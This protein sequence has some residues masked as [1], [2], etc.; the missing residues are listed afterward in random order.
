M[1]ENVPAVAP[2]K[3]PGMTELMIRSDPISRQMAYQQASRDRQHAALRDTATT[4]AGISWGSKMSEDTRYA[5]AR[6]CTMAGIDP[7]RHIDVLGSRIYDNAQ[8]YMD[9]L[10][11][12]PEFSHDETYMLAPLDRR[13]IDAAVVGAENAK[14]LE[15]DRH[16]LNAERLRLQMKYEVPQNINDFPDTAA[17]ALVILHFKDGTQVEG[18]NWAGSMGRKR[19]NTRNP[20][21]GPADPIGDGSAVKTAITRAYRKAAKKK[22]PIWFREGSFGELMSRAEGGILS[23][24]THLKA[25]GIDPDAPEVVAPTGSRAFQRAMTAGLEHEAK[26]VAGHGPANKAYMDGRQE[27]VDADPML[28]GPAVAPAPDEDPYA[29]ELEAWACPKC[30]LIAEF[31]KGAAPTCGEC[32]DTRMERVADAAKHGDP[33]QAPVNTDAEPG[34]KSEWKC[35]RCLEMFV[36]KPS[37]QGEGENGQVAY[38][39][40]CSVAATQEAP[41]PPSE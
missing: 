2:E 40:E 34:D 27:E 13:P 19:T 9:A 18:V 38:C 22:V 31:N 15:K 21:A 25:A 39:L 17:A 4:I 36:G 10:A 29:I 32:N 7:I 8:L 6:W 12:M 3:K 33:V 35:T 26:V 16:D 24:R 23:D 14:Q 28:A 37:Y 5:V 41:C 30:G 1:T 11:A 20:D